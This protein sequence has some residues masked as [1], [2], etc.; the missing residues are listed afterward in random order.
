MNNIQLLQLEL[1]K[2]SSFNNFDGTQV[3]KDLVD[4]KELWQG[5][6]MDRDGLIKLRDIGNDYWNVDT[7]YVLSTGKDDVKLEE[8]AES[9]LADEYGFLKPEEASSRLGTS[10]STG[11]IM[12]VWWD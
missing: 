11:K 3:A 9:W 12:W 5:V 8:L 1:I 4:N 6:I 2:L 7:L 10:H